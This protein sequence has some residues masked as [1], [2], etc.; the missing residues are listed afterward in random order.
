M[1]NY[2]ILTIGIPVFN[3]IKYIEETLNAIASQFETLTDLVEILVIDNGSNDGTT[4]LIEK[5]QLN[6][7][8]KSRGQ[9]RYLKN[10]TNMGYNFNCD[11]IIR[12]AT[13]NYLWTL[14]AQEIVLKNSINIILSHLKDEPRQIVI[15][16]EVWDGKTNV[17]ANSHIYGKR[18]DIIYNNPDDFFIELG[19]PCRSLSLNIVKTEILKETLIHP[20][21][22]KYWGMYERHL[23]ASFINSTYNKF[24]FIGQPLVRILIAEDGWQFSGEDSFGTVAKKLNNLGFYA[25]LEVAQIGLDLKCYGDHIMKSVGV[26][27]DS[28]GIIRTIATAK[29]GGLKISPNLLKRML[30]IYR[31]LPWFW[32]LGL[33]ILFVPSKLL[34]TRSLEGARRFTHLIR[35]LL[36]TPAK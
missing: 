35:K 9:F 30:I 21:K 1:S 6:Y 23:Y 2:P 32:V 19:G 15:N 22:T 28:F 34:S 11:R 4:E 20:I 3:E 13:G 27:R 29:C 5:L 14:G 25:D 10:I 17:L 36:K 12:E 18:Q 8:V 16:A 31:R 24:L 26:W 33:P 7:L